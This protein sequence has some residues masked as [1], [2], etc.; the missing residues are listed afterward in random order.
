MWS[1]FPQ[2]LKMIP[3]SY[4]QNDLV[5][6]F[7]ATSLAEGLQGVSDPDVSACTELRVNPRW[8]VQAV[9]LRA[10]SMPWAHQWLQEGC[11]WRRTPMG[12]EVGVCW[13]SSLWCCWGRN[14]ECAFE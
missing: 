5:A 11:V 2:I 3:T 8:L 7:G 14:S 6:L 9:G 12:V 4:Q 1:P 10:Q 13:E